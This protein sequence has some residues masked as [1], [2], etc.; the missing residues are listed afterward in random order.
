VL[1]KAPFGQL[2]K[3]VRSYFDAAG[4]K[5]QLR[6]IAAFEKLNTRQVSRMLTIALEFPSRRARLFALKTIGR[7]KNP[8]AFGVLSDLLQEQNKRQPDM[9]EVNIA[10]NALARHQGEKGR[11]LLRQISRDTKSL[12]GFGWRSSIRKAARKSL[13]EG[14]SKRGG[15]DE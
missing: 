7:H 10:C 9:G 5:E 11:T 8:R 2:Q 14:S 6:F 3:G 4:E 13:A 12:F 1:A 15:S